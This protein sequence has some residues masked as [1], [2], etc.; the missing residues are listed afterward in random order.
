MY[1]SGIGTEVWL[2]C[3][4]YLFATSCSGYSIFDVDYVYIWNCRMTNKMI[5]ITSNLSVVKDRHGKPY[6]CMRGFEP[7]QQTSQLPNPRR[8]TGF[9]QGQ[10]LPPSTGG[11]VLS[12]STSRRSPPHN[13]VRGLPSARHNHQ[14]ASSAAYGTAQQQP[15][16]QAHKPTG[17]RW[18]LT[19]TWR[20]G[21]REKATRHG[22]V[23]ISGRSTCP[24]SHKKLKASTNTW[25]RRHNVKL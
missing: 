22:P 16:H 1:S 21:H 6:A 25:R 17:N 10:P 4:P 23:Y 2:T 7:R 9:K 8:G 12:R 11:M 18:R 20:E 5:L 14:P 19:A 15:S 13:M 3:R 24:P